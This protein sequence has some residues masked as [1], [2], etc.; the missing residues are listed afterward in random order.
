MKYF[1]IEEVV[2]PESYKILGEG[3]FELFNPD[4]LIALDNLREFFDAPVTVNTW[5]TGGSFKYRGYRPPD[6]KVGAKMSQHR[7]GNA[8][9]CDI[10]GYTAEEA[11]RKIIENQNNPLLEKIMR[12][13]GNVGWV[14]WDCKI[15]A[16]NIKRIYV[17]NP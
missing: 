7:F 4:A 11:R 12:M 6:C 14:H 3:A 16:K 13:E 5:H 2:D 15:L 9:D 1:R 17:F 10:R 8:F